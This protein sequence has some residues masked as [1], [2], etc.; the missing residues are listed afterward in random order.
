MPSL[1]VITAKIDAW[2][3]KDAKPWQF[4]LPQSGYIGGA[5]LAAL[6]CLVLATIYR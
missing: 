1:S 4:W 2:L 5:I 6:V 3:Y